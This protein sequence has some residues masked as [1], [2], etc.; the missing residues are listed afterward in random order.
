MGSNTKLA[1]VNDASCVNVYSVKSNIPWHRTKNVLM[2]VRAQGQQCRLPHNLPV[3]QH[4]QTQSA[5]SEIFAQ[6]L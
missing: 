3:F 6:S 4:E 5:H 2:L 1:C